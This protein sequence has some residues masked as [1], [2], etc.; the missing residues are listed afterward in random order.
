V[1]ERETREPTP[2]SQAEAPT[3]VNKH[4]QG[5]S[6]AAPSRDWKGYSIDLL[7]VLLED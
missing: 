3:P 4:L 7:N 1:A 5:D 6:T 2:E